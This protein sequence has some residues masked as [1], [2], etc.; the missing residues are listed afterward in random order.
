MLLLKNRVQQSLD[1]IY[2][3]CCFE[4]AGARK[5]LLNEWRLSSSPFLLSKSF[6]WSWRDGPVV[7][8]PCCTSAR[9]RVQ[10][11]APTREA[12]VATCTSL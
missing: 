9:A 4:M 7:K 11:L 2:P 8:G 1:I 5:H 6:P 10:M 3:M 12:A